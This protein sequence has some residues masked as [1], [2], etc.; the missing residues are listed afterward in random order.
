MGLVSSFF[1]DNR[2]T[3]MG[4]GIKNRACVGALSMTAWMPRT[5]KPA[6]FQAQFFVLSRVWRQERARPSMTRKKTAR[7][8][9]HS[10][11][12]LVQWPLGPRVGDS[13]A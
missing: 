5:K 10:A 4:D 7:D 8:H 1:L 12:G 11:S 13:A 6:F 9:R 2:A 3:A